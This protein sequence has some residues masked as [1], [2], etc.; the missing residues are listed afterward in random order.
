MK[1]SHP[2]SSS[3]HEKNISTSK[4]KKTASPAVTRSP[5]T[6][7]STSTS[8]SNEKN[9]RNWKQWK[10]QQTHD[11]NT[12]QFLDSSA[13]V[14]AGLFGARRLPEIKSLW[15]HVVQN[16]VV[17]QQQEHSNNLHKE[18]T[19]LT[20]R[21]GESGGGK[22][23]SRHL[24]RRTGSHKR[25]RRHRFPRGIESISDGDMDESDVPKAS[26]DHQQQKK[27]EKDTLQIP[28]QCRRARR[29]PALLKQ[30][31]SGWWQPHQEQQTPEISN[32]IPTHLWHAKRF[33]VSS[34]IFSWSVPLVNAN[35]GSRASLRL[36]T[37]QT[38]P[39]CTIQDATWEIDGGAIELR[40]SQSNSSSPS[41]CEQ[42][43][44]L[45]LS[46]MQK[47]TDVTCLSAET[48][49]SG[50]RATEGLI[51]EID[52]FPRG[53]VGPG[54]FI[55][56]HITD[57]SS[58]NAV[59]LSVFVHP[60]MKL[61]VTTIFSTLVDSQ[62]KDSD[63]NVTV[64]S[65]ESYSLLRV[66]GTSSTI[67]LE[68][69]LSLN[70]GD[71]SNEVNGN[72]VEDG[73]L[74]KTNVQCE[75]STYTQLIIKCHKPN[76]QYQHLPQ[77]VACSGW[78]IF[79]HPSVSDEL[80]QTFVCKGGS[81]AIGLVED[82]RAQLE[83]YPPLPI[84]PRDFPDSRNG[85]L[86]WEGDPATNDEAQPNSWALI[87]SCIEGSWGRNN[88]VLSRHRR[89]CRDG[90]SPKD[91]VPQASKLIMG[92]I[93]GKRSLRINWTR[94][95]SP[96]NDEHVIIVRG[97]FGIPFLQL[98]HGCGRI[99]KKQADYS[100]STRQ[101]K[102]RP[103]RPVRPSNV[104]INAPSLSKEEK[105][106]HSKTCKQLSESLSLPA[107]LRCELFFDGKGSP[108]VGDIIFSLCE[109]P[110]EESTLGLVVAGGFSPSRG[111]A[112]AVA[113]VGAAKFIGALDGTQHGMVKDDA[114]FLK[115]AVANKGPSRRYALLSPLL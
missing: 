74:L 103:R 55:F 72:E 8:T 54:T 86:Y 48:V 68:N 59:H 81:C 28:Q 60:A 27:E 57:D 85:R 65:T 100:D 30:R 92:N 101:T 50:Q 79:C 20:R 93:T 87:R 11:Y 9:N 1:R 51:H 90:K 76:Q 41:S 4:W 29:K 113:F 13:T 25:R 88:R 70:W 15:R 18:Q 31:H 23:S 10:Q 46:M 67:T 16:E 21:A 63:I 7:T 22:I 49:T 84:F 56:K 17:N 37:S 104:A 39:K 83:A 94:L 112:Y 53:I 91:E 62:E 44:K 32:W 107:L 77:N 110:G 12:H 61:Q 3:R 95:V 40:A 66:R 78:D 2:S 47:I 73:T 64:S 99:H 106:A 69:V 42:L 36:A 96:T 24:R 98:L 115:V 38:T 97:S 71:I 105:I 108:S 6:L 43:I 19:T 102:R 80:F 33:H 109:K 114:M 82:A 5:S 45:L 52:S 111:K 14:H 35:R 75:S 34:P 89:E 26:L 58:N